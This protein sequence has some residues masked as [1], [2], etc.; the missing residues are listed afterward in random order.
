MKRSNEATGKEG[1]NA[2]ANNSHKKTGAPK[3]RSQKNTDFKHLLLQ[4]AQRRKFYFSKKTEQKTR[5]LL[6][7][8]RDKG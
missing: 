4:F 6:A 5:T 2:K 7:K 8:S 1:V 3:D